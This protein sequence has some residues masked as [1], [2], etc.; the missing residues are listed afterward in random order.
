MSIRITW[1][2]SI[3]SDVVSYDLERA[4]ALTGAWVLVGNFLNDTTDP[5][6]YS[7]AERVFFYNDSTGTGSS[8]YR[9]TAIDIAGNR[10]IPSMPFQ[11]AAAPAIP[12]NVKLDHNYGSVA[13]LRY[14]TASGSPVEGAIIRVYTKQDFDQGRTDTPLAVSL[15][16]AQ[17]NWVNPIYV[18]TGYTYVVQFAKEGLYGP[19]KVEVTV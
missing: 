10:S 19:D 16:N 3:E 18:T 2:P 17:G 15:T 8:Y 14:Q 12:N 1:N 11:P 5:A 9:L 4:P 6:K 13:A 7:S